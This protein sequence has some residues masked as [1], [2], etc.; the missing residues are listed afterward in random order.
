[1]LEWRKG[2]TSFSTFDEDPFTTAGVW[3]EWYVQLGREGGSQ[4][5]WSLYHELHYESLVAHSEGECAR[6]CEF[7]GIPYEASMLRFHEGRTRSKRGLSAKSAWL[8]V[9]GGLRDWRTTMDAG[10]VER[11]EA[12]AGDLLAELGY[13]RATASVSQRARERAARVR[14]RFA[15]QVRA[16]AR[17]MPRAWLNGGA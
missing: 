11:F 13:Q 15:E 5:G 9:T 10:D 4:L 3:W 16:R 17:P 8:P 12:A 1:V 14:E 6:L 2:V 7:L